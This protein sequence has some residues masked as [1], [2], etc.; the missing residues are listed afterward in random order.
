NIQVLYKLANH[1]QLLIIFL[2]KESIVWLNNVKQFGHHH[3]HTIKMAG[4]LQ[5]TQV[6][7][8]V[9][10]TD[11]GQ[12]RFFT[13]HLLNRWREDDITT[14]VCQ[15]LLVLLQRTRVVIKIFIG[16]KLDR[17]DKD[18]DHHYITQLTRFTHQV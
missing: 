5:T 10:D 8:N 2:P 17:I 1:C 7:S 3:R 13:I 15:K 9:R 14:D 6:I 11:I 4:A 18:T 12:T 16:S